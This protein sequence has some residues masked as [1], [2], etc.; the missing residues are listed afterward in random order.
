[1]GSPGAARR[2]GQARSVAV[3]GGR[4]HV[5]QHQRDAGM[6]HGVVANIEQ[7]GGFVPDR[8]PAKQ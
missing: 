5:L 3:Q 6:P 7:P 2:R 8:K 1:M 4:A